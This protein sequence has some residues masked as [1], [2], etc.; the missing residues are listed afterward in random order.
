M[1]IKIQH[2]LCLI[3]LAGTLFACQPSSDSDKAAMMA[4]QRWSEA[5]FCYDFHE[6]EKYVTPE[7]RKWLQFAATNATQDDIN[8]INEK[9]PQVEAENVTRLYGEETCDTLCI[10]KLRVKDYVKPALLGHS[11]TRADEGIFSITLVL[12]Q[13]QWMVRME[14]LPR[15]ERQSH[16]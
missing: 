10:V 11:S 15:N 8:L 4:A 14:G 7:S 1:K 5:Y 2:L 6:A 3:A 13:D 9:R 16:D 12:V